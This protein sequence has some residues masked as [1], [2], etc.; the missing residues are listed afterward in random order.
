MLYGMVPVCRADVIEIIDA[1][2]P[3][4]PGGPGNVLKTGEMMEAG[5]D[6]P[7]QGDEVSLTDGILEAVFK[8][9]MATVL[10]HFMAGFRGEGGMKSGQIF[11][12]DPWVVVAKIQG[13]VVEAADAQKTLKMRVHGVKIQIVGDDRKDAGMAVPGVEQS[14]G[15]GGV[16]CEFDEESCKKPLFFQFFS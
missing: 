6:V 10:D 1:F 8:H 3:G 11:A 14:L 12:H 16:L 9:F 13:R 4:L 7:H 2:R 5:T 15:N